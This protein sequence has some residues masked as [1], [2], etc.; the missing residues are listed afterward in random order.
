[1]TLISNSDREIRKYE[2]GTCRDNIM[3]SEQNWLIISPNFACSYFRSFVF[4]NCSVSDYV[5]SNVQVDVANPVNSLDRN[6]EMP[7]FGLASPI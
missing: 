1:V 6:M 7:G 3:G 2:D 5:T 4:F